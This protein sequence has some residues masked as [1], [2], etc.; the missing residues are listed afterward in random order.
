MSIEV[1]AWKCEKCGNYYLNKA[2]TDDCCKDK[3]E[4]KYT[5]RVC[6]CETREYHLICPSCEDKERFEKAKKVKYSEYEVGCLWDETVNEY[7]SDKEQLKEKYSEDEDPQVNANIPAW[8]Y[9]CTETYFSID[10]D[11]AIE[12]ALED[13]Y[14]DFDEIDDEKGLQ[15]FIKEWNSKQN[16]VT[17]NVDYSTVVLLNE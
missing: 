8:C 17:Y 10:I 12:N 13:M 14:E 1:K 16:G 9:G 2:A 5:C 11:G 15:D 4:T 7:F 3:P 6:G